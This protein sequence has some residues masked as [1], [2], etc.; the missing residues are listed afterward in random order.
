MKLIDCLATA[1][2]NV[3]SICL[4]CWLTADTDCPVHCAGLVKLVHLLPGDIFK[5]RCF[6]FC[7]SNKLYWYVLASNL[8][9]TNVMYVAVVLRFTYLCRMLLIWPRV[10][11]QAKDYYQRVIRFCLVHKNLVLKIVFILQSLQSYHYD[12]SLNQKN[13]CYSSSTLYFKEVLCPIYVDTLK[14]SPNDT[15]LSASIV[16]QVLYGPYFETL[17][18]SWLYVDTCNSRFQDLCWLIKP[19]LAVLF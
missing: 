10:N 2:Q 6:R 8:L 15:S 4:K 7:L 9:L 19:V 1:Y 5:Y 3:Y 17:T 12:K 11:L 14:T 16:L 18:S 13:D